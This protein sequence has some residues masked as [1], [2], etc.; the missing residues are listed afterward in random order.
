MAHRRLYVFL[1]VLL[2]TFWTACGNKPQTAKQESQQ[3]Q[4][5]TTAQ[6]AN[7]TPAPAS[8]A[9]TQPS[10]PASS[11]AA[12][13][14]SPAPAAPEPETVT[15][16]AGT[17]LHIRLSDAISSETATA[18]AAF[19]GTLSAPLSSQGQ[20]LIP[21]GSAVSGEVTDAEKGGRLHHPPMLALRLTSITPTGAGPIPIHTRTWAEQGKSQ[22]KRNEI[23]IGGGAGVGALV[24][25]IAGHGKGAAIGA[26]VGAAGGTA[27]A[28]FTGQKQIV[29]QSEE[30]LRF[31]LARSIQI[32]VP[33]SGQ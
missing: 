13:A 22:K 5:A 16:P 20:V 14:N 23:G 25:A 32:T 6:P 21:A 1:M 26:A 7:Q 15:I 29:L 19:S 10:T 30:P 11:N 27:G 12:P 28:A 33:A 18:G 24:G 3:G 2:V 31:V 4:S 8:S 17:P 9:S